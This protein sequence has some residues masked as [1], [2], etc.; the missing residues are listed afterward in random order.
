MSWTSILWEVGKMTKTD[1]Q[2]KFEQY[3]KATEQKPLTEF[4]DEK[5]D[6]TT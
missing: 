6:K 5:N 4:G 1:I 2:K 3:K